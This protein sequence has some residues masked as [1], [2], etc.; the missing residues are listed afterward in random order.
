MTEMVSP[1]TERDLRDPTQV[2][3]EVQ[4]HRG[5]LAMLARELADSRRE[6]TSA[7]QSTQGELQ[8]IGRK[9][10]DVSR[11]QH[12]QVSHSDG[13]GRAFKAL[14]KLS[15]TVESIDRRVTRFTGVVTGLAIV[16]GLLGAALLW[17]Y[18]QGRAYEARERAI[19]EARID[20]NA[21]DLGM[22]IDR[23]AAEADAR[24]D[25]LEGR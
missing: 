16:A 10:E 8:H 21:A 23:T 3:L 19:L 12:D 7:W 18:E 14:E 5:I 1:T 17:N 20:R 24:L 13:L 9:M 25:A 2:M 6:N 11:L 22:R 15:S 4:E